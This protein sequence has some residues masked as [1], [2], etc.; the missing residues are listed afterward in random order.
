M[1]EEFGQFVLSFGWKKREYDI[2]PPPCRFE[3]SSNSTHAKFHNFGRPHSICTVL[4]ANNI[5]CAYGLR[6]VVLN[7][8][9]NGKEPWSVRQWA[10]FY[11][12]YEGVETWI[13]IS[14]SESLEAEIA[15]HILQLEPA[16]N[17]VRNPFEIHLA[18][19][20]IALTN[21]RLYIKSLVERATEQSTRVIAANAGR[22]NLS[23][24]INFEINFEDRQILQVVEEKALD[25]IT[26]FEST[27]DTLTTILQEYDYICSGSESKEIDRVKARL[28]D[29]LREVSLYQKKVQTLCKRIQ[30]TAS[31]VSTVLFCL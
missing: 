28:G 10:L 11:R 19:V 25:L 24:L 15:D 21:W 30:G 14:P 7:N 27:A 2:G 12:Y 16:D 31:L 17:S 6:Y 18:L 26:I 8:H 13:V 1:F 3:S 29:R 9:G 22:G 5:E 20:T 4:H 23:T